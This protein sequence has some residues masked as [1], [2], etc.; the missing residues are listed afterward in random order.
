[1]SISALLKEYKKWSEVKAANARGETP[2]SIDVYEMACHR[3][4]TIRREL[5]DKGITP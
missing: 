1:M 3:L 2:D 4:R 5:K